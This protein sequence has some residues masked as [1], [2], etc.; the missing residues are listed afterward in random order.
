VSAPA[1]ASL[2][3]PWGRLAYRRAGSGETL[4]LLHSL[5]LNGEMWEP[6]LPAF[7][8]GYDVIAVDF[9]GHG[10]SRWD[11]AAFS[12]DD[13]A[14]DLRVLLDSLGIERCHVLGV[15]M[16]GS[17]ATAFAAAHPE[18]VGR[19]VL[20]DTTA[21]YGADAPLVWRERAE[22]ARSGERAKLVPFQVDRWFAE[23]FRRQEPEAVARVVDLFLGTDPSAHAQACRALGA[24]DAR[25][26]LDAI[27]APTWVVTGEEDY[28]T[29]PAMG[30]ALAEG[31]GDATFTVWPGVRH[32]AIF[33]SAELRSA[34][35]RHLEPLDPSGPST[36][37]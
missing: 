13:L 16:G 3:M 34:I 33:E 29:P 25:A 9:R 4:L 28:A 20:C 26:D 18:L 1:P 19:L 22:A 7:A 5:A 30:S 37:L 27:R 10:A 6:I 24:L 32:L 31:I 15:S 14:S 36:S 17:V 35:L 2:D 21:W 8:A 23:S 12:V 11:G